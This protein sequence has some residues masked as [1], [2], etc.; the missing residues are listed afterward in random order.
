MHLLQKKKY[1]ERP[2]ERN[3]WKRFNFA[4]YFMLV[5]VNFSDFALIP[6]LIS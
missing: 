2:N 5:L 3:S 1:V 4:D 6:L